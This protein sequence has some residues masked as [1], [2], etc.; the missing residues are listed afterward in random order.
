MKF[1]KSIVGIFFLSTSFLQIGNCFGPEWSFTT[2]NGSRIEEPGYIGVKGSI[3]CIS[4]WFSYKGHIIGHCSNSRYFVTNELT[5]EVVE[6]DDEAKCN[7][8]LKNHKLMPVLFTNWHSVGFSSL[9]I[10]FF[11]SL[12]LFPISIPL[13][14]Y[15]CYVVIKAI[16]NKFSFES[17]YSLWAI[18]ILIIF[19][20]VLLGHFWIYVPSF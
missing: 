2:K 8:Y 5:G 6:F 16:I 10:L 3:H 20:L 7:T 15:F 11:L 9:E 1:T 12:L 17:P 4:D 14:L 19:G 18:F 13:Y